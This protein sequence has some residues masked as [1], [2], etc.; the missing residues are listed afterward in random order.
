[1]ECSPRAILVMTIVLEEAEKDE[2]PY[3][4]PASEH[5]GEQKTVLLTCLGLQDHP[6]RL[7]HYF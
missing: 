5:R 7:H 4:P 3:W 2:E 6:Q 1:M